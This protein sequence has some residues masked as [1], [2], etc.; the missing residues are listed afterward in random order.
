MTEE[1]ATSLPELFCDER[2]WPL[3]EESIRKRYRPSF[4]S[5]SD[6]DVQWVSNHMN[7]DWAGFCSDGILTETYDRTFYRSD[8]LWVGVQAGN[9]QVLTL[10]DLSF[11]L[12]P[13]STGCSW[14]V[15]DT[16]KCG[17][18]LVRFHPGPGAVHSM[19]LPFVS[20]TK[21]LI[22]MQVRGILTPTTVVELSSHSGLETLLSYLGFVEYKEKEMLGYVHETISLFGVNRMGRMRVSSATTMTLQSEMSNLFSEDK[23]LKLVAIHDKK[24]YDKIFV[25]TYVHAFQRAAAIRDQTTTFA[26]SM[27]SQI[28]RAERN[29]LNYNVP[30]NMIMQQFSSPV[31]MSQALASVLSFGWLLGIPLT[32]IISYIPTIIEAASVPTL[33]IQVY[34]RAQEDVAMGR[35]LSVSLIDNGKKKA[36]SALLGLYAWWV[37]KTCGNAML[38]GDAAVLL[39]LT[40]AFPTRLAITGLG[41]SA[42]CFGIDYTSSW[43][44]SG[45]RKLK[46]SLFGGY[47]LEDSENIMQAFREC[48]ADSRVMYPYS[49]S[50]GRLVIGA[51]PTGTRLLKR[52][53]WTIEEIKMRPGL[54][55]TNRQT[56]AAV[57]PKTDGSPIDFGFTDK[58][59]C[60]QYFYI[61][62]GFGFPFC[63]PGKSSSTTIGMLSRVCASPPLDSSVQAQRWEDMIFRSEVAMV[64]KEASPTREFSEDE[65]RLWI[66]SKTDTRKRHMYL[67]EL[68]RMLGD[69]DAAFKNGPRCRPTFMTKFDEL[70]PH[71]KVAPRSIFNMGAQSAVYFGPWIESATKILKDLWCPG[72]LGYSYAHPKSPEL[73]FYPVWMAGRTV[74]SLNLWADT[75]QTLALGTCSAMA[76]GDDLYIAMHLPSGYYFVEC[77]AKRFDQSQSFKQYEDERLSGPLSVPISYLVHLGV[78]LAV[79]DQLLASYLKTVHLSVE[80]ES[81]NLSFQMRDCPMLPTGSAATTWSNTIVSLVAVQRWFLVEF[82]NLMEYTESP[83]ISSSLSA[84]FV[85]SMSHLGFEAKAKVHRV[86]TQGTFLKGSFLST[87]YVEGGHTRSGLYWARL[88]GTYLKFG[89]SK[90][91][92]GNMVAY[93]GLPELQRAPRFLSDVAAGYRRELPNLICRALVRRFYLANEEQLMDHTNKYHSRTEELVEFLSVDFA[94]LLVRYNT[95]LGEF[96]L[97]E[98]LISISDYGQLVC[99]P[100]LKSLSEDF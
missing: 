68:E 91:A 11:L 85:K 57:W 14:T 71:S 7:R 83:D 81:E 30:I 20:E 40:T 1:E 92:L 16:M 84:S 78:P 28:A 47:W 54:V 90:Q 94:P 51:G 66:S 75:V 46:S 93:N 63:V 69:W 22:P 88:P 13:P 33:L 18:K 34:L 15:K 76:A 58:E 67:A 38:E 97:L 86:I 45:Y 35:S 77:D 61:H 43:L 70:L 42:S 4:V 98:K 72:A 100:L 53:D 17:A 82:R 24:L 95:T 62:W 64:P 37:A 39:G 74:S 21:I 99:S 31:T 60:P 59:K 56:G 5:R 10:K 23:H 9:S 55:I 79:G 73:L 89:Y 12:R 87:I 32:T 29:M 44:K 48:V 2:E 41:L 80:E 49:E 26:R 25:D 8:H 6:I 52:V 65:W 19:T 3:F 36:F 50:L 96:E 27:S